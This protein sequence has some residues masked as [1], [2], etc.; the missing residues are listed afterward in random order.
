MAGESADDVARRRR[1]KA[2]RLTRQAEL[3]EQ[4]A[5]GERL[6][7]Q[8]LVQLPDEWVLLHDVRWPGRQYAN[9]DHVAIGPGGIFVIDSKNWSGD[10]VVRNQVLRQNGR[11]REKAVLATAESALAIASLMPGSWAGVVQP[12][13][14]FAGPS[15]VSGRARDVL[16]CTTEDVVALLT[17]SRRKL[18]PLQVR[19]GA[20]LLEAALL[21]ALAPAATEAPLPTPTPHVTS[22][23]RRRTSTTATARGH[24]RSGRQRSVGQHAHKARSSGQSPAGQLARLLIL[25]ALVLLLLRYNDNVAAVLTGFFDAES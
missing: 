6:T 20:V 25:V 4:G 2:E 12:V 14:C 15:G 10:V 24:K 3:Y 9:I 5:A 8:A 7:A 17:T 16:L 13:I 21:S 11:S 1:E 22:S 19:E 18:T 23:T